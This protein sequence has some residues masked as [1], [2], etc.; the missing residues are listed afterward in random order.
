MFLYMEEREKILRRVGMKCRDFSRQLSYHR[1]VNR[2]KG[3]FNLHFWI[4]VFNNA[5][6]IAIL[7]WFHLFGYHNDDL[8]WKNIVNDIPAFRSTLYDYVEL[9]EEE[10]KSYREKIKV[11]RDKDVAH[12][13]IRPEPRVPDMRIALKAANLYY[14]YVLKELSSFSNYSNEPGDLLEYCQKSQKQAEKILALA[15]NPTRNLREE[16]F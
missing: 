6:D 5:I 8:H 16:V 7:D 14:Q 15:Y 13:E 9:D 4:S 3:N 10:W 11:Y 12:I 1:A 2:Y